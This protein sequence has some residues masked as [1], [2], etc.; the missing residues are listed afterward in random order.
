M[1]GA[2]EARSLDP[3]MQWSEVAAAALSGCDGDYEFDLE[4]AYPIE[5]IA[6]A[7]PEQ[8]TVVTA[9]LSSRASP[10]ARWQLRSGDVL[11]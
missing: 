9:R 1:S 2:F 4:A 11:Y 6:I 5:R 10:H 7:L 8:N 3:P